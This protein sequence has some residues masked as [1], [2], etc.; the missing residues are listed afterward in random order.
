MT[1][2]GNVSPVATLT[3]SAQFSTST[4]SM[5]AF[6]SDISQY[7]LNYE[8]M[9]NRFDLII[10]RF[11]KFAILRFFNVLYR[12]KT[13]SNYLKL[14]MSP[15]TKLNLNNRPFSLFGYF[16]PCHE[17]VCMIV[18][19]KRSSTVKTNQSWMLYTQRNTD[20]YQKL[21]SSDT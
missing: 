17:L 21:C 12:I 14:L 11:S 13:K 9:L 7:L 3:K 16:I 15:L 20:K 6:P 8:L 18:C 1:G 5:L 2:C 19:N 10:K 4:P